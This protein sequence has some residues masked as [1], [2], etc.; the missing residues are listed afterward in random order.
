MSHFIYL[1]R[2]GEQQDAEFGLPDGPL[3]ERGKLQAAAI[4]DRLAH[5]PFTGAWHSPLQRAAETAQIIETRLGGVRSEQSHLLFD[6][7]PSGPSPDMPH[8]FEPFFG[9]VTSDEIEA[10]SAQM[11]DAVTE[12]LA[13]AMGDRHDLLVTHNFVIGWFVREVL[14]A[15]RWRWLG[16]NQANAGLTIIRVR[17]AKPPV[18]VTH[19]DLGHL[20]A[21]LRTGMPIEQPY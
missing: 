15:P 4:A 16:I 3:S 1:V 18:L 5:V 20:P 6:C 13:P 21:E 7:F 2:H 17:S 9:G 11:A 10:G 12:F 19:N 8:A 14:D